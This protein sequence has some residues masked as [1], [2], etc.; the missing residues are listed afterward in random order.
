MNEKE[1]QW[2]SFL[3]LFMKTVLYLSLMGT[4]VI[5]MGKESHSL[6][7]LSRTMG[8]IVITFLV[9]EMLFLSIYGKYDIPGING[10]ADESAEYLCVSASKHRLA[11]ACIYDAG[12]VDRDLYVSWE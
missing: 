4:F 9:V 7:T 12:A 11:A 3:W 5:C 1:R 8:I 2:D 6:T 10:H